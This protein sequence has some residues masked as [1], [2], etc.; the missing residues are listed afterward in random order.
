MRATKQ[1]SRLAKHQEESDAATGRCR[2]KNPL[3]DLMVDDFLAWTLPDSVCA[4]G[5]ATKQGPGRVGTNLLTAVEARQMFESVVVPKIEKLTSEH[6]ALLGLAKNAN[7]DA[8]VLAL[9]VAAGF[10]Q[11]CKVTEARRFLDGQ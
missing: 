6:A 4:D 7:K 5:C 8:R 11:D 2:G 10:C 3:I 1:K 9:L